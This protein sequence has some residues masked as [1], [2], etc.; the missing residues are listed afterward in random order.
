MQLIEGHQTDSQDVSQSL[1]V[2]R[3]GHGV[4]ANRTRL[5][6]AQ[7]YVLSS[8]CQRLQDFRNP[9]SRLQFSE[10]NAF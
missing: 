7:G 10:K 1:R 6:Q 3:I 2:G 5:H 4:V 8:L 9:V